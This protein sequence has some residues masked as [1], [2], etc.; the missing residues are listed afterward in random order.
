MG[1]HRATMLV[2][3]SNFSKV[4][5]EVHLITITSRQMIYIF[6]EPLVP[7]TGATVI[8]NSNAFVINKGFEL[9]L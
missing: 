3:I 8:K 6:K 2:L 5:L 9:T 4:S 1:N 7:A